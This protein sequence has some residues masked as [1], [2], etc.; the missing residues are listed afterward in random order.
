MKS[1]KK[2]EIGFEI[3]VENMDFW[4]LLY[5]L[6]NLWKKYF[7]V[8]IYTS[9]TAEWEPSIWEEY[10]SFKSTSVKKKKHEIESNVTE[11]GKISLEN[12]QMS[13]INNWN[14]TYKTKQ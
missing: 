9:T 3:F 6:Q 8:A 7:P 13:H 12:K 1:K 2:K 5:K 11:D 10:Q 4:Y 14:K